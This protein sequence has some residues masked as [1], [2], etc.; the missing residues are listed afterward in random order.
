[1]VGPYEY[2]DLVRTMRVWSKYGIYL[3]SII[4]FNYSIPFNICHNT[5]KRKELFSLKGTTF[6]CSKLW[7]VNYWFDTLL[8]RF[9]VIK[10]KMI[11]SQMYSDWTKLFV[12]FSLSNIF[13]IKLQLMYMFQ[14]KSVFGPYAHGP[15]QIRILIWS[16]HTRMVWPLILI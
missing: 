16:D 2:T 10:Y 6:I 9:S 3:T 12:T 7:L 5:T 4:N 11:T 13:H 14:T 1:M 8:C 15:D